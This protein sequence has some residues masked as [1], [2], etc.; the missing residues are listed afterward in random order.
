MAEQARTQDYQLSLPP[1]LLLAAQHA[2]KPVSEQLRVEGFHRSWFARLSELLI[3]RDKHAVP[4]TTQPAVNAGLTKRGH[5]C[6][7]PRSG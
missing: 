7:M 1:D 4:A 3:G 5:I 2:R 6:P